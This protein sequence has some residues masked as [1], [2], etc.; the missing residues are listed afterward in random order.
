MSRQELTAPLS[1]LRRTRIWLAFQ[2]LAQRIKEALSFGGEGSTELE[3]LQSERDMYKAQ[4]D[5]LAAEK[6]E[7][8]SKA[9]RETREMQDEHNRQTK[10]MQDSQLRQINDLKADIE[11]TKRGTE[12]AEVRSKSKLAD[13]AEENRLLC[14]QL[15]KGDEAHRDRVKE[16]EAHLRVTENQLEAAQKRSNELETLIKAKE[17]AE[18]AEIHKKSKEVSELQKQVD[19]LQ[20]QLSSQVALLRSTLQALKAS[21]AKPEDI[22]VESIITD[23]EKGLPDATPPTPEQQMD[24]SVRKTYESRVEEMDAVYRRL[25]PK[26][27]RP[28]KPKANR[29][30]PGD[31]YDNEV[32]EYVFSSLRVA[33]PQPPSGRGTAIAF[34]PPLIG[35]PAK[36]VAFQP[37]LN[38]PLAE[39][40]PPAPDKGPF[41]PAEIAVLANYRKWKRELYSGSRLDQSSIRLV[42]ILPGSPDDKVAIRMGIHHLD[43]IA[44][45]YEGLSYVCG[46]PEPA[47]NIIVNEVEVPINPNL[48]DALISLRQHGSVRRIWIDAICINQMSLNEKSKE[49]QRMGQIYSR[50]KTV[51]VFLGAPIPSGSTSINIFLKFLNRNDE[52]EATDRYAKDGLR[53]LDRIC[54]KCQTDVHNVCKGFIE[55]CL[56]PW[57]GRVWTL[58]SSAFYYYYPAVLL[59][60]CY[61]TCLYD[62]YGLRFNSDSPLWKSSV[63][64]SSL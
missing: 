11:S 61:T 19:E 20:H 52:G 14:N 56:Q 64:F 63:S 51:N 23:I 47:K 54:K 1:L 33:L 32:A 22:V 31:D 17:A 35:S 49:V 62:M 44:M 12:K 28:P 10:S 40:E 42:E 55:V 46:N 30:A 27:G 7:L 59:H 18:R 16:I 45:Q 37:P 2:V 4:A 38:G 13:L 24:Y 15:Q 26:S 5:S 29:G 41:E 50:A 9:E 36:T 39:T 53:E 57:W 48:H 34:Q 8:L 6:C 21:H 60:A 3:R 58:V 25:V 43:E